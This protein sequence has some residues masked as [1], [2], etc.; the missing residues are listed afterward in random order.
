MNQRYNTVDVYR[1]AF[2]IAG[3]TSAALPFA[4]ASSESSAQSQIVDRSGSLRM[5]SQRM[6]KAYCQLGM[7]ILP[8]EAETI[9]ARSLTRFNGA[10]VA[11]RDNGASDQTII[12]K[13]EADW[14][15]FRDLVSTAPTKT[16][17]PRLDSLSESV[18]GNA[19]VLTAQLATTLRIQSARYTNISGRQR[20]LSQ[21]MAKS[22]FAL[23][24]GMDAKVF[25]KQHETA[26][27]QFVSA[28]A[29]LKR[30][31]QKTP[32]IDRVLEMAETQFGFFDVALG[33]RSDLARLN[34][35]RAANVAKS[36]ERLLELFDELTMQFAGLAG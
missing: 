3:A 4:I 13:I 29:E 32:Q 8:N 16:N 1:R 33:N 26:R 22:A 19:E 31:P 6:N 18:L 24:W 34:P 15:P 5:L 20:M 2:V 25:V 21:R 10:M 30:S 35:A 17:Y 12:R 28:L 11:L 14:I 23:M 9:L 7:G 27:E 36:N